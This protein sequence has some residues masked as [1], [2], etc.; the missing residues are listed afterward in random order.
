MYATELAAKALEPTAEEERLAEDY[1][2][3]LGS[4]SA[5]EQALREGAWHRLRDEVDQLMSAAEDMWAG[6]PAPE[7]DGESTADEPD[8][9][10]IRQL[11]AVYAQ[12]YAVGRALYPTTVIEDAQV[13]AAV[14]EENAAAG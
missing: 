10:K 9:D 8:S 4:L 2:T 14:E 1:V 7:E 5:M 11:V 12:P 3:V 6:L 13:R